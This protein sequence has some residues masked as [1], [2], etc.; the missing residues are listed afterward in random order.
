MSKWSKLHMFVT[1]CRGMSTHAPAAPRLVT[2]G[3]IED[4]PGKQ[5][6]TALPIPVARY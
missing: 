4:A 6:R 5:L 3:M 1:P 2:D